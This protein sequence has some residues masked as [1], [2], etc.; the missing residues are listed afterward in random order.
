[1]AENPHASLPDHR[2]WRK[3]VASPPPFA[4]DPIVETPF[5]IAKTDKV[6]TAGSRLAQEI[7]H[8]LQKSGYDYYLREEPPQGLS[9]AERADG[10][11]ASPAGR[12]GAAAPA[13]RRRRRVRFRALRVLEHERRRGRARLSGLGRHHPVAQSAGADNFERLSRLHHRDEGGPACARLDFGLQGHSARRGR[14]GAART[15]QHRLFSF[16]PTRDR[17]AQRGALSWGRHPPHQPPRD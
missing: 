6:A 16:L 3:A 8:P 15:R 12:R 7:A 5:K 13:R 11:L 1:M 4:L 14:R 9:S 2:F 17:R 10:M